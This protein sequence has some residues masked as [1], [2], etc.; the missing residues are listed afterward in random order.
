MIGKRKQ[1][2]SQRLLTD[3]SK[4]K[5]NKRTAKDIIEELRDDIVSF[6]HLYKLMNLPLQGQQKARGPAEI[7][8]SA[9]VNLQ[10]P[11]YS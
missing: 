2:N 8:L 1:K 7:C 3:L 9:G 5:N 10:V 11:R 4:G 6:F